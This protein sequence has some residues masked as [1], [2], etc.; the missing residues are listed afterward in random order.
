MFVELAFARL[1]RLNNLS[2]CC[3][4]TVESEIS[5][6]LFWAM[7]INATRLEDALNRISKIHFFRPPVKS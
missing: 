4:L 2:Q 6:L 3:L 5:F 1:A 7:T